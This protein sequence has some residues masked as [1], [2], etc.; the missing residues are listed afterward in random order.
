VRARRPR[1]FALSAVSGFERTTYK[2]KDRG[3]LYV[4]IEAGHV[5]E[6]IYLASRALGFCALS[7]ADFF[8]RPVEKLLF[9]DGIRQ[10]ALYLIAVGNRT[11]EAADS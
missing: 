4:L 3:Y 11:S 9:L 10:S 2:Y 8:D 7:F 6:N 5:A 1:G